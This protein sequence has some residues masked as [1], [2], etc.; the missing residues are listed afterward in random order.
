VSTSVALGDWALRRLKPGET[1]KRAWRIGA[2]IVAV[3]VVG[4]VGRIPWVGPLVVVL[5][6]L[7][8]VGAL[9]LQWRPPPSPAAIR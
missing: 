1:G 4:L 9:V 7:A 8:G 3:L 5:V 2:A 6:L